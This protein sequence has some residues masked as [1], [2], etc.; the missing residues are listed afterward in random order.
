MRRA[1]LARLTETGA[2]LETQLLF[3]ALELAELDDDVAE[4]LLAD[5]ALERL[6]ASARSEKFRPYLLTEPEE[7]IVTEKSV[8]GVSAWG[9]LYEE[10]LGALR[11]A[12]RGRRQPRGGDGQA[13]LGRPRRAAPGLRGGVRGARKPYPHADVRVQHG[14]PRQVRRRPPARLRDLDLVPQPPNDT[15]DEAV[16]ALIDA[17]VGRATRRATVLPLKASSM[18]SSFASTTDGSATTRRRC[19]G[20]RRARSSSAPTTTSRSRRETSRGGSL[21]E[22]DRRP[23]PGEQAHR[24]LLRDVG[25]GRTRT[26]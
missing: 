24:C 23:R 25:A 9:R 6:G 8:S 17:C 22:L 4:K 18:S 21:A 20:T 5:E 11:R 12:R 10:L 1:A 14:R 13:V 7:K 26:C 15:S 2:A 3:F 19:R 16:Q